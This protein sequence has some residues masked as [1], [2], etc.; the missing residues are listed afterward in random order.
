MGVG[1]DVVGGGYFRHSANA[2][3][4]VS[5]SS[6]GAPNSTPVVPAVLRPE[7]L[8]KLAD[9]WETWGLAGTGRED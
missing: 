1:G 6:E 7:T 8:Q 2:A 4:N 5:P 9:Y 3:E